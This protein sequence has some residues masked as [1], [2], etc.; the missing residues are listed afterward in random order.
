MATELEELSH[1]VMAMLLVGDDE[2]PATL[3]RQYEVA[4]IVEE[5]PDGVGFFIYYEVPDESL[6]LQTKRQ[7][8]TICDVDGRVADVEDAVGFILFVMDGFISS[9]EGYSLT[10]DSWPTKNDGIVLYYRGGGER[11]FATLVSEWK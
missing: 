5:N 1:S 9:L 10:L 4:S 7:S 11:D 6:R 3:R 2:V 8:F